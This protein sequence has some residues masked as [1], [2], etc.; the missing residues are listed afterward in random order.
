MTNQYDRWQIAVDGGD[1]VF[2]ERGDPPS[3][4]YR[5]SYRDKRTGKQAFEAF[6][7][8]R[9]DDGKL[10][11]VRNVFGDGSK[12]DPAEIDE[13]FA[14]RSVE[15]IFFEAYEAVVERKE[16]WPEKVRELTAVELQHRARNN[17]ERFDETGKERPGIGDNKPPADLPLNEALTARIHDFGV[18]LA[19]WLKSIGGEPR[20][21]AEAE[22]LG[23]YANKF[24]DF[25][26]QATAAHKAEKEPHLTAGRQVDAKWFGPVRDKAIAS[27]NRV[28]EIIRAWEKKENAAREE[29]ARAANAEAR[30]VAE[31]SSIEAPAIE[32]GE[33]AHEV[34]KVSTLRGG[35]P[36]PKDVLVSDLAA[37]LGY[38]AGLNQP[39]PDIIEA[40]EKVA[41]KFKAAGVNAPGMAQPEQKRGAA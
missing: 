4:F 18:Q 29:A 12:M 23:G 41:R 22:I 31:K 38:C 11:C 24:K 8:Y 28:I 36:K 32:I 2:G 20:T 13:M 16:I 26:N 21:Q 1:L 37:F 33:V 27:R 30:K 40:A 39:P 14:D 6:C 7:V 10:C 19:N 34:A 25:E 15:P 17:P 9:D 5:R 3:G 35:G